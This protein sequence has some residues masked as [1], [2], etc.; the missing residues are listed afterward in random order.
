[1]AG[2]VLEFNEANFESE[3]L[4]S[5]VPVLVDFWATWCGPCKMLIPTIEALA[6]DLQGK[7]RIG[8]LDTDH[9]RKLAVQYRIDAVPTMIVFHKGQPVQRMM[10]VQPKEK[11][12]SALAPY[13][14]AA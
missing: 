11:I 3:V 6:N 10:G 4:N 2:N 1:M 12:A 8:K 14:D 9:S 7:A 13:L 5:P